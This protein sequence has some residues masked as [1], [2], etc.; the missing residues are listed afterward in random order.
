MEVL[1]NSGWSPANTLD[2]LLVSI[3]AQLLSGGGRLDLHNRSDY[4]E[5]EA[6]G[7]PLDLSFVL[8]MQRLLIGWCRLTAGTRQ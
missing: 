1:T 3:R 6:K 7:T 2:S 8:T 5:F 4:T